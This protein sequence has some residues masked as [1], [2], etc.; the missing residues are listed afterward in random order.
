MKL[1][2]YQRS[3][4]VQR[5]SRHK[6]VRLAAMALRPLTL[7]MSHTPPVTP[8]VLS[9]DDMPESC[10]PR[11]PSSNTD[12]SDNSQPLIEDFFDPVDEDDEEED[13]EDS[14][15][16]PEVWLGSGNL[17]IFKDPILSD[18]IS[19]KPFVK[20]NLPRLKPDRYDFD[21]PL[22]SVDGSPFVRRTS[23]SGFSCPVDPTQIR[24]RQSL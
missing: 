9:D 6:L 17:G 4:I 7:R 15:P 2:R 14:Y 8:P 19:S 23:T 10:D 16:P 12:I 11:S 1:P 3:D 22:A 24:G 20:G 5:A 13:D 21:V 18:T